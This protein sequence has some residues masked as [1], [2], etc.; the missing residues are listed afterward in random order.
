[1]VEELSAG[2][3]RKVSTS[4]PGKTYFYHVASGTSTWNPPLRSIHKAQPKT[5]E[6]RPSVADDEALLVG[7]EKRTSRSQPGQVYYAKPETGETTWEPPVKLPIHGQPQPTTPEPH[8]PHSPKAFTEDDLLEGWETRESRSKPG[9]TF[10]YDKDTGVT[11]WEPPLKRRRLE[12][13]APTTPGAPPPIVLGALKINDLNEGWEMH[14]S[15]TLHGETYYFHPATGESTWDPPLRMSQFEPRTPT[16]SIDLSPAGPKPEAPPVE[17][18]ELAD[19]LFADLPEAHVD[20]CEPKLR[21][22]HGGKD[23]PPAVQIRCLHLLIKH[24]NS[25]KPSSWR[26]MNITRSQEEAIQKAKALRQQISDAVHMDERWAIFDKLTRKESDCTTAKTGGDLG[27]F[28]H[29]RMLPPFEKAAFDLDVGAISQAVDS[30]AGIHL[31][32]RLE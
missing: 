16:A 28:P 27:F 17:T 26:E 7:W 5:P 15:R 19:D 9:C 10:F 14:T 30:V 2:W 3:E 1:M 12:V 31:I 11:Q 23:V 20:H 8:A 32:M 21:V 4:Q 13:P 25:R 6:A 22:Q 18:K 29:G 24:K